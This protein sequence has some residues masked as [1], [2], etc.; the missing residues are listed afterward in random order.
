V[1]ISDLKRD[2]DGRFAQVD[3]QFVGLKTDM[4]G[5]FGQVDTRLDRLES[6]MDAL[7]RRVTE[8]AETTRRHF[9]VVAERMHADVKLSLEQSTAT[10]SALARF[11]Q[12]NRAEHDGMRAML[13]DH[14]L[15]LRRL[16]PR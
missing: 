7:E 1:K 15:R 16:E 12:V 5:R 11:E 14:D 13:D 9:D 8:E 10:A 2:L 6:R 3:H 4:D